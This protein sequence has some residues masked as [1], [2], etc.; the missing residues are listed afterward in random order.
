MFSVTEAGDV[1]AKRRKDTEYRPKQRFPVHSPSD[2]ATSFQ[3]RYEHV[4]QAPL[5]IN[6]N[7][8]LLLV[9]SAK[10]MNILYL[11]TQ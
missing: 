9:S 10:V 8:S 5:L 3:V 7:L 11:T 4:Q 1:I 2:E 6:M